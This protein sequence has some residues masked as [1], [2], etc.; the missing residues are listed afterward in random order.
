[1]VKKF[2]EFIL[3]N[4]KILFPKDVI[5][6]FYKFVINNKDFKRLNNSYSSRED[7][8]ENGDEGY[9]FALF[10]IKDLTNELDIEYAIGFWENNFMGIETEFWVYKNGEFVEPNEEEENYFISNDLYYVDG[11]KFIDNPNMYY[12]KWLDYKEKTN[13]TFKKI[14]I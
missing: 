13:D 1:M 11:D 10:S 7:Y 14:N 8:D 4:N 6:K 9:F 12:G 2:N 3:E 5:S